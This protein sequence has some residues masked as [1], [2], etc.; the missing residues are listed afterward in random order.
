GLV[1]FSRDPYGGDTTAGYDQY[2]LLPLMVTDPAGLTTTADYDYRL[3]KPNL[4]IDP[5]GNR[6]QIGYTPLGLP[7][8]VARLG[9]EGASEGDTAEQPSVT[10]AYQLT[11]WDE[12]SSTEARQPMSVTTTRRVEHRW[13]IADQENTR[14]ADLGLP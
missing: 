3:L 9:K 8:W 12:S 14:R 5:N 13:T 6:T 11:A 10:Y 1:T 4:I 2:Q 7:A